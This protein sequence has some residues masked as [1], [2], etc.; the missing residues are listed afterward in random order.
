MPTRKL[1]LACPA[2]GSRDV[3]YTCTP[4]CCFNHACAECATTFEPVTKAAGGYLPGIVPPVPM[5]DPSD[6]TAACARCDLPAVCTTDTG[7]TVCGAC[8]ALLTLEL[9]E[10]HT[11]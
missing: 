6:P 3:V 7:E 2:C 8:G 10:I 9:T 11:G 1:E 4:N 5:P